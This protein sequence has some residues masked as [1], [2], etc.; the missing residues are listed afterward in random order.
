MIINETMPIVSDY[1]S[2]ETIMSDCCP[3]NEMDTE[4]FHESGHTGIYTHN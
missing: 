4:N 1:S 2:N 3:S